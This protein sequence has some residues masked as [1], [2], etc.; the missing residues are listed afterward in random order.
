MNESG[1]DRLHEEVWKSQEG[2]AM[3][4]TLEEVCARAH[5]LQRESVREF[6]TWMLTLGFMI[7]VLSAYLVHFRQPLLRMSLISLISI[8][9]YLGLRV[10]RNRKP[11]RLHAA[12]KPEVC[13]GFLREELGRKREEALEIRWVQ[14]LLFPGAL[15]FWWGGGSVGVIKWLGIDWPS[16][17]WFHESPGPLTGLT[18]L[19]AL[20]WILYGREAQSLEHE[21]QA[22]NKQ[23]IHMTQ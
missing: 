17:L 14:W 13:A 1:A 22:I 6:W 8:L 20:T 12:T 3:Q 15:G 10:T 23:L 16:V 5:G 4:M 2:G 21:I 11:S 7:A 9:L 19:L 18:A